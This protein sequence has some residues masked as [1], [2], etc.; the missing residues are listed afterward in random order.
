[1]VNLLAV[2]IF[3][4]VCVLMLLASGARAQT[5][6]KRYSVKGEQFSV[7]LPTLPAM[8][9]RK[10]RLGRQGERVE[11]SMGSYANGV[12]YTVFVFE[13]VSPRQSFD[14]FSDQFSRS[15]KTLDQTSERK[16]TVDGVEG[17][18]FS[19]EDGVAQFFAKADRLYQFVAFGA[20]PDDRRIEEFFSSISMQKNKDAV[21]V[22]D[23]PG[24]P[25]VP[26]AET[27]ASSSVADQPVYVGREVN[28]K[29]RIAMKPEPSY[30]EAARQ[31]RV[32]G[33]V[34]LKCVFASNGSVTNIRVASGLP[35][36]LTEKAIAAAR[37]IKFL[38]AI[39]DERH[40]SM[41][42]VLEYNFDIY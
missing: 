11:I 25:Y 37:K 28:K 14:L 8:D 23:G 19:L 7:A 35:D 3:L 21:D 6:W 18:A 33:T 40:V 20:R 9:Y 34:I 22:S 29:V 12:V 39:K 38:P 24:E 42:M 36:G 26:T 31:H 1:M 15:I 16:L 30:T 41:W 4:L 17:K 5:S 13:N 32:K 10:V 27:G 2:R